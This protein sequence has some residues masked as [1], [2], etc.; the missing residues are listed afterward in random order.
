MNVL[1]NVFDLLLYPKSMHR[2]SFVFMGRDYNYLNSSIHSAWK[3]ERSV[4]IPIGYYV[5]KR[6]EGQEILE[7]GNTIKQYF[8][9]EHLDHDVLDKYEKED[10][11]I[12]EDVASF[13]TDKRYNLIISI[14][15][16]E[17]VGWEQDAN[18][19]K[20]P[21]DKGK[22]PKSFKNLRRLFAKGGMMFVTLP[23]GENPWL[24]S[25]LETNEL[26]FDRIDRKSVV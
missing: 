8:P 15:T 26:G 25:M 6:F 4:E 11:V 14:S 18:E 3:T 17:H 1:S 9:D 19:Y 16:M 13:D 7:V 23:I 24:D 10:G 22:I 20:E 12:N 5:L 21:R 2:E